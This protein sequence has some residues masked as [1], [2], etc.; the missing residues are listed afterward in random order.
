MTKDEARQAVEATKKCCG[1]KTWTM[2]T[3]PFIPGYCVDIVFKN[4]QSETYN[5]LDELEMVLEDMRQ[6]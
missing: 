4:G 5:D 1:V 3:A 2:F 6:E